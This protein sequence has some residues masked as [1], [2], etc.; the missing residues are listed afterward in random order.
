[1]AYS[2]PR[3][4]VTGELVTAALMNAQLRDNLDAIVEGTTGAY[5]NAV[6]G[7]HA[8]GGSTVDYVRLGLTGA[9]TSG[10]AST[11]A[12]GLYTSGVLTGHS[13]DSAAIAGIKAN[14]SIVTAGNCTTIAQL[15]VAEPQITVGAGAVTNSATVYIEGAASEASNDYSLFVDDGVSRFDGNVG[16]GTAT[17]PAS[18]ASIN[19]ILEIEDG[20]SAGIV[21]HD[22]TANAWDIYADG[23][24]LSIGYNNAVNIRIEGDT[25]YCAIGAP[26]AAGAFAGALSVNKDV[27]LACYF[28]KAF[29]S[30]SGSGMTADRAHFG[31]VDMETGTNYAIMQT[32]AGDTN[33]NCPTGQSIYMNVNATSHQQL[34]ATGYFR[35][36]GGYKT[37]ASRTSTGV[38]GL[39]LNAPNVSL[40]DGATVKLSCNTSALVQVSYWTGSSNYFGGLFFCNYSSATMVEL[41]DPNGV[42]EVTDTGSSYAVY[43]SAASA[44]IYVKNRTG[45]A[46][47]TCVQII[48]FTGM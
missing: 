15:W 13:G 38:S 26:G 21:L 37:G 41:A 29:V 23:T 9:F 25:G 4:W 32:A 36:L 45:S 39:E 47:N 34:T 35:I 40:A 24:D 43:K 30:S 27:D 31:H 18:P 19:K 8:I 7:P 48:E 5:V 14:N 17:V 28:G 42:F 33:L 3:T 2:D 1:M 10:G 22:T 20:T 44:D 46:R 6:V 16:V 12:Y 11:V